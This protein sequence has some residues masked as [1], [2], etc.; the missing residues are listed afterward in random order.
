MM[1]ALVAKVVRFIKLRAVVST[2]PVFTTTRKNSAVPFFELRRDLTA[3]RMENT[4]R[5]DM[6][7]KTMIE[8]NALASSQT[9]N[10][11]DRI[12]GV[13]VTVIIAGVSYLD[14]KNSQLKKEMD[15]KIETGNAQLKQEMDRKIEAGNAQLKNEMEAGNAQLK[16][17]MKEMDRKIEEGNAQLKKEMEA[18]NA[19]LKV[20]IKEMDRK[21]EA[22]N[23]Q[24]K[25]DLLEALTGKGDWQGK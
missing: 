11:M 2:R 24:L 3:T 5:V 18:G 4:A 21:I 12:L 8:Q 23:A 14:V 25:K 6:L 15:R 20:E 1:I 19:Q 13:I 7:I 16:V 22:G 17:E 9:S 10:R